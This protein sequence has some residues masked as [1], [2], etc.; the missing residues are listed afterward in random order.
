MARL[1]Y[2]KL[3]IFSALLFGLYLLIRDFIPI[4]IHYSDTPALILFFAALT[5]LVHKGLMKAEKKSAA[6]FVRFYIGSTAARM[7]LCLMIMIVFGLLVP[8]KA[9]AFILTFFVLYLLFQVFEVLV[10]Y[11]QLSSNLEGQKTKTQE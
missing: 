7:F 3:L 11:R 9:T 2:I 5:L 8:D 6:H 10:L 4:R 1:Y